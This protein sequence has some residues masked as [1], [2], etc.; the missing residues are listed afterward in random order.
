M[1]KITGRVEEIKNII[2]DY[3]LEDVYNGNETGLFLQTLSKW[4][5]DR[6]K[7]SLPRNTSERLRV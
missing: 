2:A 7:S 1:E 3:R 6:E 4:T 5:L